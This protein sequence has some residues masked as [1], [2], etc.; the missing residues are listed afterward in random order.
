MNTPS[1]HDVT[2]TPTHIKLRST[3]IRCASNI[4]PSGRSKVQVTTATSL[5]NQR[6]R[7][8][9]IRCLN[10]RK[11]FFTLNAININYN[12]VTSCNAKIA[13][14]PLL[15]PLP[16]LLTI[17]R[18]IQQPMRRQRDLSMARQQW[19]QR[20][21]QVKIKRCCH[22]CQRSMIRLDTIKRVIEPNACSNQRRHSSQY[23]LS[24]NITH[25]TH[26]LPPCR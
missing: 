23:A 15:K 6:V 26:V 5:N 2:T 25:C 11:S 22:G 14:A 8:L 9:T 21:Q 12:H 10:T 20:Q 16:N 7:Q 19:A 1:A 4:R 3:Q 17:A 13:A 18:R 24:V